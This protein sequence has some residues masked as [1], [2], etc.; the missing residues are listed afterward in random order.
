MISKI[1]RYKCKTDK[2]S[3]VLE[4]IDVFVHEIK[5]HDPE[6]KYAVYRAGEFE[7]FHIMSF[8]SVDA[9][10]KH[11]A[12][13]YT[14]EFVANLYPDCTKEVNTIDMTLYA[15]TRFSKE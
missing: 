11:R 15:T 8:S 12:A 10:L 7:F 1:V 5:T 6:T 3:T 9:E 4:I 2:L 13:S 14:K